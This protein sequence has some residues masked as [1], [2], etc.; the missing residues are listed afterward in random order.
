MDTIFCM[1][2]CEHSSRTNH[3]RDTLRDTHTRMAHSATEF[4]EQSNTRVTISTHILGKRKR[5]HTH[6]ALR[7][8]EPND[9]AIL[10]TNM[11]GTSTKHI[12]IYS[13]TLESKQII[14]IFVY[15][16]VKVW[17]NLLSHSSWTWFSCK[18]VCVRNE[19]VMSTFSSQN[20][21]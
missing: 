17:V 5:K 11:D 16:C 14:K 6:T 15:I 8:N 19:Y 3:E 2:S 21:M 1:N 10:S 4:S 9:D 18:W 13:D 7:L 20:I 12:H